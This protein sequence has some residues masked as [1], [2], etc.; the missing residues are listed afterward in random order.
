MTFGSLDNAKDVWDMLAHRYNAANLAQSFQIV[1]KLNRMRQEPG[2]SIVEFYSQMT[3]LWNQ[4]SLCEPEWVNPVDASRYIAF[5]DSMRLVEFL[6][7]IRDEFENTRASLLHRSPLPSLE[8][9]LSELISEETR[10]STMK[11][12]TSEMVMATAPRDTSA[13]GSNPVGSSSYT[14]KMQCHYCHKFGHRIN[15]CRARLS[16]GNYRAPSHKAAMVTHTDA[17][18]MS[19]TST[20]PQPSTLSPSDIKAI[21]HQVLSKSNLHT[22]MSTTSGNSSWFLDSACYNHMTP[23]SSIFSSK[24]VLADPPSIYTAN[25]SHL[26]VS[27]IGSISTKQ[28][29]VSNTYLVPHLSLNLLSVG[30]LC[31]LDLELHFSKRGCDV[32]DS[33]MGPPVRLDVC[34]SFHLFIFLAP[35]LLLLHLCHHP[36]LSVYGILVWDM[37]MFL[38][39]VL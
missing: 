31:E 22:A 29:S 26:N 11:L 1:T 32:Q 27:H 34:L 2:Q 3:Y 25:G 16:R 39:F 37:R 19:H 30:Q 28:L 17:S 7:A 21:V 13:P 4:M 35:C 20:V 36:P 23:D 38:V 5:R 14:K 9:A 8:G 24:S 10:F 15:E 18:D 33:Q 12:H 6:T